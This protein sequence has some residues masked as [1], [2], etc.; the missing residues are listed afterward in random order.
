VHLQSLEILKWR[1]RGYGLRSGELFFSLS[2]AC[3]VGLLPL[4]AQGCANQRALSLD[5]SRADADRL[6][7]GDH[8]LLFGMKAYLIS[9]LDTTIRCGLFKNG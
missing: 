2:Q 9:R 7:A 5:E 6:G 8:V 4:V 3:A 1:P